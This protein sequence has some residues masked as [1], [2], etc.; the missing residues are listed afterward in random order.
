MTWYFVF[1]CLR[2]RF[3]SLPCSASGSLWEMPDTNP[4]PLP[5]KSG[6]LPDSHH[7]SFHFRNRKRIFTKRD[8]D[9]R[10]KCVK[11]YNFFNDKL[12]TLPC[13]SKKRSS[14]PKSVWVAMTQYTFLS[15]IQS[16][17]TH[18]VSSLNRLR[19]KSFEW[20]EKI[21]EPILTNV[22][23]HWRMTGEKWL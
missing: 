14:G 21:P 23:H 18:S 13:F 8:D 22:P 10:T 7:I 1:V 20:L 15:N 3:P 17:Y 11:F 9:Y 4:G 6:P 2:G 19:R 5:Q 12:N 16:K